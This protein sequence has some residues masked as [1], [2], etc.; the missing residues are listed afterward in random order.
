MVALVH[1]QQPNVASPLPL[2]LKTPTNVVALYSPE[3]FRSSHCSLSIG[4]SPSLYLAGA[5]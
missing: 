1:R 4:S 5:I 2:W 3:M